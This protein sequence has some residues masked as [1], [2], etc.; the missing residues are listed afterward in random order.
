[1]SEGGQQNRKS[2]GERQN[3]QTCKQ[4]EQ[5]AQGTNLLENGGEHRA[6]ELLL[7]QKEQN[8]RAS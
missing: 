4:E 8:K 7:L 1:V 6:A 5:E 2:Y 3:T